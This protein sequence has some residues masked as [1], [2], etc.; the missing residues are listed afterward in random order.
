MLSSTIVDEVDQPPDHRRLTSL[1]TAQT[2]FAAELVSPVALVPGALRIGAERPL[3]LDALGRVAADVFRR[4]DLI[5][6]DAVLDPVRKS[7]ENIVLGVEDRRLHSAESRGVEPVQS[8][9]DA[10]MA[11]AG[12]HEEPRELFRLFFAAELAHEALVEID[13]LPDRNDRIGPALEEDQLSAR[14]WNFVTS[15]GHRAIERRPER[16]VDLLP[17]PVRRRTCANPSLGRTPI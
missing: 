7:G 1:S 6:R 10:A 12:D 4:D 17:C 11:D 3:H 9:A 15:P 8:A 13:R 16:G 5:R 2:K 14:S